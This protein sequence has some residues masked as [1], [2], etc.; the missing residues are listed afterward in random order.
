MTA[1]IRVQLAEQHRIDRHDPRFAAID[2]AAFTS[3][4]L[5]NAALYV[6]D[7]EVRLHAETVDKVYLPI[8]C[9]QLGSRIQYDR[10]TRRFLR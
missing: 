10:S 5:Y 9:S 8:L 4:N 2:A 7:Q 6:V 1:R 3:K